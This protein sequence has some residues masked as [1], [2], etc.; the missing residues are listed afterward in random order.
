MSIDLDFLKQWQG[1]TRESIDVIDARQVAELS[2]ALDYAAPLSKQGDPL[3]PCWHWLYFHEVA[4]A[5]DIG[6]DGHPLRGEFLPPVPLPRRM[7]AGGRL[8]FE[9]PVLVGERIRRFS[10][11]K[12]V[13]AKEGRSGP[14]VFVTLQHQYF[15]DLELCIEEEQDIVY[16][17]AGDAAAQS[18]SV[19]VEKSFDFSRSLSPDPVL[20]F[21]YSA[22]TF[23]SHRIHYDRQYAVGEE[24]YP[25]LVV[26]GPLTATLL[27][28]L[29]R[30]QFPEREV[31]HFE[32]RGT[33][34]VFANR[35]LLLCGQKSQ[36]S[37]QM[38]AVNDDKLDA[39]ATRVE[40]APSRV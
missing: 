15:R 10:T 32:F 29:L 5:S 31:A 38:W 14:L 1:K 21:R 36:D 11:V 28:D 12:S 24:H 3:P 26:Q 17:Q 20:L 22:L 7:W 34:P 8:N 9:S 6:P 2:A 35:S 25:G 16:R 13:D 19:Q 40:L 37:V 18:P 30:R 33:R 4:A 23:N 39:M 27:L